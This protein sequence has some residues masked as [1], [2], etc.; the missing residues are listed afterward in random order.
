MKK[1]R[2]ILI[3]FVFFAQVLFL[4]ITFK[5][6]MV[7]DKE[8]IMFVGMWETRRVLRK[9]DSLISCYKSFWR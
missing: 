3:C 2:G 5:S 4:V 8:I 6:Q 9:N 7:S 1:Q